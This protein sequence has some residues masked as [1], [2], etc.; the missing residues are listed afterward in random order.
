MNEHVLPTSPSHPHDDPQIPAC[1]SLLAVE[2]NTAALLPDPTAQLTE[3][4]SETLP[5]A[6][7]VNGHDGVIFY[8]AIPPLP[9]CGLI[10]PTLRARSPQ[11]RNWTL[12]LSFID[13]E[14]VLQTLVLSQGGIFGG[15]CV[16]ELRNRG[17]SIYHD[18]AFLRLLQDW[19]RI[20]PPSLGWVVDRTGWIALPNVGEAYVQPDGSLI[21]NGDAPSPAVVLRQPHPAATRGTLEGWH[22]GVTRLL[23]RNPIGK[24]VIAAS[25]A[26]PL[27]RWTSF[28][29]LALNLH[30]A[31]TTGKLILHGLPANPSTPDIRHLESFDDD[32]PS[33]SPD[34]GFRQVILM[35]SEEATQRLFSRKRQTRSQA[36]DV[37]VLDI[38]VDGEAHGAF[39]DLAGYP[40]P[41]SFVAALRRALQANHGHAERA[42]ILWITQNRQRAK[43]IFDRSFARFLAR[44]MERFGDAPAPPAYQQQ[45]MRFALV[46]ATADVT[47]AAGVLPWP[48][49]RIADDVHEMVDRWRSGQD[50]MSF[51]RALAR[52][53]VFVDTHGADLPWLGAKPETEEPASG[54]QDQHNIYVNRAVF[55]TEIT[56]VEGELAALVHAGILIP[57]GEQRSYQYKMGAKQCAG[58]PRVYCI[59]KDGLASYWHRPVKNRDQGGLESGPCS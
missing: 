36:F 56:E 16:S 11:G 51:G 39:R 31:T 55:R 29:T 18:R 30:G 19:A 2:P 44:E 6:Y 53:K 38:P 21:G 32:N 12:E 35:T 52:L 7:G 54:C 40:D 24:F 1:R 41:G 57:G 34:R 14:G 8:D 3:R 47:A 48:K 20:A 23:D 25:L 27:I 17:F 46:A 15:K 4:I 58:R 37:R 28:Q 49:G 50:Q 13:P 33:L 5:E 26:G 42:L 22:G 10:C 45:V 9:I 59:S 43:A